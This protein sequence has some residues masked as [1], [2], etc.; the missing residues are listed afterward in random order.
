SSKNQ[1][2]SETVTP[3]DWPSGEVPP[4]N[5]A[6]R[7]STQIRSL[8][9]LSQRQTA[10]YV[11]FCGC[12]VTIVSEDSPDCGQSGR[13]KRVFWREKIPWVLVRFRIGGMRAVPWDWTDLPI[14]QAELISS[15]HDTSAVFLSPSA[16][17]DLV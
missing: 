9:P 13:V 14:P 12:A 8:F 3:R 10:P 16:L 17:R 1:Q 11:A 2:A 5:A 4:G 7:D 6:V 15:S